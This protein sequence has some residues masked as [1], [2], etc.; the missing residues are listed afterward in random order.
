LTRV[1]AYRY[2]DEAVAVL[3]A[4]APELTAALDRVQ[5]EGWSHLI[6]DGKIVEPGSVHDLLRAPAH[7]LGARHA[8]AARALPT[9]TD[10]GYQGA[11]TGI[12]TPVTQPTAARRLDVD[13]TSNA[14][15]RSRR[16]P[17][18]R[19]YALLVGRWRVLQHV[20]TCPRTID[21]ITKG[22]RRHVGRASHPLAWRWS[23]FR[24]R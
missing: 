5:A 12:H 3:A 1:T 7:A 9:L 20:T 24:P 19:G 16:A 18:E 21:Q 13:R 10:P 11:G 6:R 22:A 14:L 23:P 4:P 2:R 15:L 8:A 17:G